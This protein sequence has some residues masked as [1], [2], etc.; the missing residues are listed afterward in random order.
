MEIEIILKI[1]LSAVLGGIIGLEREISHKDAGLRTNILIAVGSTLLTILS[2]NLAELSKVGDPARLAAHIITGIGFIGA[3][4]IIQARFSIHGL[5]TAATIWSVAAIGIA[6][7]S[8]YYSLSLIVTIVVVLILTSLKY[9]SLILEKQSQ[10]YPYIIATEDRASVLI[11]IKKIITE[12]GIKYI[13]AKIKKVAE[14]Y[15][16]EISLITSQVKNQKFIERVMQI[17]EVKET[18]SETL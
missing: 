10:L 8:G 15:E 13:N 16:I 11:D 14:G 3:G 9:I 4:A 2:I 1:L 12:L 7:G 6:V 5:T 18:V 17:P